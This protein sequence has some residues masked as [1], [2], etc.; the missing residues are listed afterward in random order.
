MNIINPGPEDYHI[1]S[2]DYSDGKNSVEEIVKHAGK[3]GLKKIVI[4]DHSQATIDKMGWHPHGNREDI[5]DW[6]NKYNNIE[7]SFGVEADLLDRYGD[8]SSKIQFIEGDFLILSAHRQIF[9]DDEKDITEAYINALVRYHYKIKFI[10][11]PTYRDFSKHLDMKRLVNAA[12]VYG[13][14]LEVNGLRFMKNDQD[15]DQ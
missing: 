1:H 15:I 7:V 2:S 12:N 4:T 9:S 13:K 3:I 5:V 10:G 6:I 11:H 14:P 8:I